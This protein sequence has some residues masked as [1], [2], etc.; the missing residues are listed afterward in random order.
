[1]RHG[2]RRAYGSYE[3]Y[4]TRGPVVV[5]LS[6]TRESTF[7]PIPAAVFDDLNDTILITVTL[8]AKV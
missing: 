5:A 1:M 7:V 4:E 3:A 2:G 6:C 8:G